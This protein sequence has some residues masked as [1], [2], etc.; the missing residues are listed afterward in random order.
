[1]VQLRYKS[2]KV[3]E[4]NF[5]MRNDGTLTYFFDEEYFKSIVGKLKIVEFMMDKRLLINRKRNLDMYRVF[6][7]S[8]LE[9]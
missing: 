1:M 2:D 6:V 5:Y 4:P 9:K 7:Q 8:V 3:I